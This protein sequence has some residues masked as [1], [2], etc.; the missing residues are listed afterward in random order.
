MSERLNSTFAYSKWNLTFHF[1]EKTYTLSAWPE[2]KVKLTAAG[3][4]RLITNN[5]FPVA[6][7]QTEAVSDLSLI[8][9]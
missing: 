8:H 9:I 5:I 4:S 2:D 6:F 3:K 1:S 7:I